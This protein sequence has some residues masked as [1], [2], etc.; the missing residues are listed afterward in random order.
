MTPV[1]QVQGVSYSYHFLEG[2]TLA[3]SDISFSVAPGE[4]IAVVGPSGCGKSTLLSLICGLITPDEGTILINGKPVS[5]S[6][7]EIGL[8]PQR[9]QLFQWRSIL[10]NAALGLEIQKKLTP[11]SKEKLH[12]LLDTYGLGDFKYSK[13]SE[14]SGGMR[15]RAAFVR[16]L[17][18][19]PELFLLD[20]PFSALDYQTRLDVCDDISSIIKNTG[21]TAILIT[22]DLSEAISV[23]DRILVLTKRPGRLKTIVPV[24]FDS[25]LRPLERRNSKD[26]SV[27]FN[28]LWKELEHL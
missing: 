22:H 10:S 27:Y 23:A 15:Q 4:F 16:T 19:E 1:L 25:K 28:Q 24:S 20:E 5:C 11:K 6:S 18:L 9:D 13:P 12:T 21:K 14:L 3:L 8:M 17:A 7:G 26:F 2:E